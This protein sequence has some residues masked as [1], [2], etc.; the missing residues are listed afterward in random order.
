MH[1]YLF[2]VGQNSLEKNVLLLIHRKVLSLNW[3]C[4]KFY[5]WTGIAKSFIFELAWPLL[6][7]CPLHRP[8]ARETSQ[9]SS[10]IWHF[11]WQIQC[12]ELPIIRN[13]N[14]EISN[15]LRVWKFHGSIANVQ[16]VWKSGCP[17][18]HRSGCLRGK[19]RGSRRNS[20]SAAALGLARSPAQ[21]LHFFG[22]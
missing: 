8:L 22:Q 11:S 13:T 1:I 12:L 10:E 21:F 17:A 14:I 18:F 2:L 3:H 20:S 16:P 7:E 15:R 4:Q 5:L 9:S 19:I 6:P